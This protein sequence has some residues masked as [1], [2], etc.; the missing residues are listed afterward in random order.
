M[1]IKKLHLL[2]AKR[3][4]LYVWL[5]AI[6]FFS[7]TLFLL[8]QA[9]V[10]DNK[11]Y[12][13][14]KL[15][16]EEQ[17]ALYEAQQKLKQKNYNQAI[18]ILKSYMEE[19]EDIS[20][21]TYFLL[22]NCWH[23]QGNVAKANQA[24]AQGLEI[25]AKNSNLLLN[26]AI[27]CYE[28]EQYSNAAKSFKELY[29]I[30]KE[31]DPEYLYRAGVSYFHAEELGQAQKVLQKLIKI[32]GDKIKPE[33]IELL[34]HTSIRLKDWDVAKSYLYRILKV[35]SKKQYWKLLAQVF[36]QQKRYKQAASVLELS[37]SIYP[38]KVSELKELASIFTYL[39]L[40]LKAAKTLEKAY[41]K[42]KD[43]EELLK[44]SQ[45]YAKAFRYEK[46][47]EIID[48]A[49][50]ANSNSSLYLKKG[51]I[52][53]QDRRYKKAIKALQK[54]LELSPKQAEALILLG[55]SAWHLRDW[56][57]AK[58]AFVKAKEFSDYRQQAKSCINSIN[59]ILR[60]RESYKNNHLKDS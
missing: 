10:I 38:P 21:R 49:I 45:L 8:F 44:L 55:Y 52:Y 59:S 17:K 56:N 9:G 57:L 60:A 16:Y 37:Y 31:P 43:Q 40:P 27:S 23:E 29:Q 54:S 20:N 13:Y 3:S 1:T 36:L 14:N 39:N 46:S 19:H 2:I 4:T 5:K 58:R 6:M 47:I 33:W 48:E 34:I 35:T 42:N 50:R 7:C 28:I 24:Y 15:S 26:Y 11:S 25:Y 18:S 12:A 51:R 22:G 53:Y 41:G 32:Q 30:S